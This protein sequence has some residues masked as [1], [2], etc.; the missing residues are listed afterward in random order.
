MADACRSRW[1][2][3]AETSTC[4]C[5]PVG[6]PDPVGRGSGRRERGGLTGPIDPQAESGRDEAQRAGGQEGNLVV[7]QPD[8]DE[9]GSPGG[10]GRAELVAEEDPAEDRT[11]RALT[12]AIGG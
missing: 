11:Q 1:D 5:V 6:P 8:V 9:A 3:R 4:P 7:A 10:G 2:M 12:E